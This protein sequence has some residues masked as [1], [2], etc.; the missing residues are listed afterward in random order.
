MRRGLALLAAIQVALVVYCVLGV[1]IQLKL[2][3]PDY[4]FS[5]AGWDPQQRFAVPRAVRDYGL[6]L[7]ALPL[8]WYLAAQYFHRSDVSRFSD[9]SLLVSGGGLC[10]ALLIL[11]FIATLKIW[12][13]PSFVPLQAL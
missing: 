3:A 7:L 9:R 6:L 13:F 2:R 1:G 5:F 10:F 4:D 12:V 11:A 8:A